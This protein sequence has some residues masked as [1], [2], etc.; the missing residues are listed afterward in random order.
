MFEAYCQLLRT[1]LAQESI[2]PSAAVQATWKGICPTRGASGAKCTR[3]ASAVAKSS[4]AKG[5]AISTTLNSGIKE[6]AN[7]F[8]GDE[9]FHQ[10][11]EV[12][13]QV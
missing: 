3:A 12:A 1:G 8:Q 13:R 11:D 2:Q 9:P 5:L 6:A 10:Q 7:T 4:L